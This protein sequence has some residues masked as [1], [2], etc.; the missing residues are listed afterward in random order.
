MY[1][2]LRFAQILPYLI[3]HAIHNTTYTDIFQDELHD[4][5]FQHDT[6]HNEWSKFKNSAP[7]PG[8]NK[9]ISSVLQET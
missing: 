7:L 1:R 6:H 8:Q 4:F 9:N 3:I 5:Y 2:S